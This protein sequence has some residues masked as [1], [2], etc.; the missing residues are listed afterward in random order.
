ML[1]GNGTLLQ[2]LAKVESSS[3]VAPSLHTY[4]CASTQAF[5]KL[6]PSEKRSSMQSKG[7]N[8][9]RHRENGDEAPTSPAL[10]HQ[11]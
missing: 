8:N 4:P 1:A 2:M 5:R 11:R 6:L 3:K 7:S 10:C 9:Y